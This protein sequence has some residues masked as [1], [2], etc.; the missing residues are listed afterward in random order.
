[1][2]KMHRLPSKKILV[3]LAVVLAVILAFIAWWRSW[4]LGH[5]VARATYQGNIADYHLTVREIPASSF[6]GYML[7][8]DAGDYRYQCEL[9]FR[10]RIP[11][12]SCTFFWDSYRPKRIGI[13]WPRKEQFTIAFDD[14]H[15]VR[16]T[17]WYGCRAEWTR[18]GPGNTR[19]QPDAA[20]TGDGGEDG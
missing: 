11:I 3:P 6:P 12:T 17:W 20:I 19:V 8:G 5:I 16:C 1:M 14:L 15:V 4:A 7:L 2:A 10:G 18:V 13:H 9:R